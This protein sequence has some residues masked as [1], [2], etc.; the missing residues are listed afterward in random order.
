MNSGKLFY[1]VQRDSK[2]LD[3]CFALAIDDLVFISTK[4]MLSL[5]IYILADALQ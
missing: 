5:S 2:G 3:R 1:S 4:G